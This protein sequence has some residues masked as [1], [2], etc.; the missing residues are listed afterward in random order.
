VASKVSRAA[1]VRL[2]HSV[3]GVLVV[4]VTLARKAPKVLKD[5]KATKAP[6]ALALAGP[7]APWVARASVV[8][9]V[10][11]DLRVMPVRLDHR[12]WL[13]RMD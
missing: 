13:D 8:S 6:Q 12:V 9:Q 4:V 3:R 10:K 7:L 11:M 1:L 5:Q 2:A